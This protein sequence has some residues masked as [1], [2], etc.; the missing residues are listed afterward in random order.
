MA[1]HWYRQSGHAWH[2]YN[3]DRKS[4][5]WSN[6]DGEVLFVSAAGETLSGYRLVPAEASVVVKPVSVTYDRPQ[7]GGPSLVPNK[8]TGKLFDDLET[9]P[10]MRERDR[11]AQ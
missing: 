9:E 8:G 7:H 2:L 6:R 11:T 4:V 5:V 3:F 1:W 10:A